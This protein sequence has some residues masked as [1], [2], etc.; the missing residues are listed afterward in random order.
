MGKVI[1]I[2]LQKGGVGKTTTAVNLS[3]SFAVTGKKTLLIDLDISGA[4]SISLGFTQGNRF[5]GMYELFNMTRSIPQCTHDTELENLKFVP[6]NFLTPV[7][8]ERL[9]RMA[10]NRLVLRHMLE[11]VMPHYNYIILDCPPHS[12]GFMTAGLAAADSVLIPAKIGHLS[13]EA[14]DKLYEYM[15]WI[16]KF[17][18]REI[19]TEGIVRTM[20]EP[21]TKITTLTVELL[22][23]RYGDV[24]LQ[25]TIPRNSTL[26]E[27][28]YYGKPAILY[29]DTSR[30]ALA[31]LALA[32]E[33]INR[34]GGNNIYIS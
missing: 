10:D 31:Y 33:L 14:I 32:K 13:I 7:E 9:N 8:E 18:G 3:A 1:A 21:R 24:L 26:S 29:R 12:R 34:D 6:M 20:N 5:P 4:A 15:E 23:E 27:A 22:R 11:Q 25:T 30:G 2:A 17:T 16:K 19:K 28:S